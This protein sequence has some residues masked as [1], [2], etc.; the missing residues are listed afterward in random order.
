VKLVCPQNELSAKLSLLSRVV[1]T[2][3]N[4]PVLANVLFTAAEGRLNLAV[5]DLNLGMQVSIPAEVQSPG[6]IT[7]PARFLNDIVTRLPN[8]P[9]ELAVEGL[10]TTITC[11]QGQYQMQGI[12]AEEFPELPEIETGTPL[13]LP[14]EMLLEGL[15]GSLFAASSDEAKQLLT[16][17]HF[18]I[19][20]ECLEFAATDGHRLAVTTAS[21][22]VE[23]AEIA[24]T[25]PAK[26]LRELERL[27][28]R[29]ETTLTLRFD[30]AQIVFEFGV[31]QE[32]AR[33]S[34]RLL[35][36]Q[37]P[38]YHQL[39]PRQFERQMTVDRQLFVGA[40]ERIAVLAAQKNNI[41]KLKLDSVRQEVGLSA[42]APQFGS[43]EEALPAQISGADLEIA[44][45]VRYLIEGL[46]AMGSSEIQFQMNAE[47]T[48]VV[49]S[50]VSGRK[51]AY[52]VM[53]IQIRS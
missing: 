27:L 35:E 14:S 13:L 15:Q 10:S 46:K 32:T 40:L 39:I 33:L 45:N 48:P 24:M 53:P 41:V 28:G 29:R 1:P 20:E 3:P 43:G 50:P 8:A 19:R 18:N 38:A 17:L 47:T 7:L 9:V 16:G 2:N 51:M 49:I 42:E 23:T 4:H 6:A 31:D 21:Q 52:L 22:A 30:P 34:S 5:F 25:V 26:A 44:F 12:G 36:G 37:Y 11:G